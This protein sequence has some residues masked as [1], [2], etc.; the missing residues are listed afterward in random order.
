MGYD[1]RNLRLIDM[2][3]IPVDLEKRNGLGDPLS[4][5][6]TA[7]QEG[8]AI[9]VLHSSI[10]R[11]VRTARR[12]LE[13]IRLPAPPDHWI[14]DFR[15]PEW[16]GRDGRFAPEQDLWRNARKVLAL[17]WALQAPV[18]DS[19]KWFSPLR[20]VL[21]WF[22]PRPLRSPRK[23]LKGL[24]DP[25]C[26]GRVAIARLCRGAY[27]VSLAELREISD[28]SPRH[29]RMDL[30]RWVHDARVRFARVLALYRYARNLRTITLSR[31]FD[32]KICAD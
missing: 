15:V 22:M 12:L 31:T 20:R 1:E 26:D 21:T 5:Q 14:R 13:L 7:D 19:R 23:F 32:C 27:E 24:P 16:M 2:H 18:E 25:R 10:C 11:Y 3:G 29:G 4:A 28:R 30:M 8:D 17:K 9:F 6:G